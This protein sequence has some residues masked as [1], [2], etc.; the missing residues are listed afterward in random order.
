ML[1]RRIFLGGAAAVLAA[2][3]AQAATAARRFVILRD[4]DDIGRH[5]VRLIRQGAD[6]RVEIDIEIVVRVLGIAAYR[7]EMTNRE[8]WRGGLLQSVDCTANDDGKRK[9]LKISRA[10]D[11]L[12]VDGSAFSGPAPGDAVTTTYHAKE[13]LRRPVWIS[14]D[15][16]E[17]YDMSVRPQGQR[18][19]ETGVG[20]VNCAT[21]RATNGSDFDVTL[22]Y[23]E[24]AD[25]WASVGFDAG[26]EPAIYRPDSLDDSFAA[27]WRS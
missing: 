15:S 11:M 2:N 4:G 10:G 20:L 8:V 27:V 18:T 14:T 19:V 23:D 1:T 21:Y 22:Y 12:G 9:F 7:Y 6:V 24:T 26:G 16:G 13:F 17:L 3:P 5:E 25:E